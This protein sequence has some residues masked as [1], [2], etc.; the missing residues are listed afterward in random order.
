MTQ[1]PDFPLDDVTLNLIEHALGGCFE[2]DEIG[3]HALV[4]ADMNLTQLLGFLSGA[5]ADIDE[6]KR[7]ADLSGRDIIDMSDHPTYSLNDLVGA[8]VAEVKRQRLLIPG[9]V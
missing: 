6:A 8:L 7:L 5:D 2:V 1:L 4:G 3:N 9:G